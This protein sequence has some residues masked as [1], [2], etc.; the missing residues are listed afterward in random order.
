MESLPGGGEISVTPNENIST[1]RDV[2]SLSVEDFA[3]AADES[4]QV[5]SVDITDTSPYGLTYGTDYVISISKAGSSVEALVYNP[6]TNKID[7]ADTIGL[8]DEGIYTIRASGM[9][10][11]NEALTDDFELTVKLSNAKLL[12]T[13]GF[14]IMDLS[15]T[16][17]TLTGASATLSIRQCRLDTYKRLQPV[18]FTGCQRQNPH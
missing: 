4:G 17:T 5:I 9:G 12:D 8:A 3:A 11:Y 6:E 14:S 16:V 2:L 15:H 1:I 10:R 18:H 7:I 13:T